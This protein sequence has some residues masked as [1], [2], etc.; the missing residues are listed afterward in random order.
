MFESFSITENKT[1][2]NKRTVCSAFKVSSWTTGMFF[3][4]S[5][6]FLAYKSKNKGG[7]PGLLLVQNER[8][9]KILHLQHPSSEVENRRARGHGRR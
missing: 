3:G 6:T 7:Y 4:I 8:K 2:Q 5:M 9:K 1:K